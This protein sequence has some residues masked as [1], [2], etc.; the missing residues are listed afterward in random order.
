MIISI[1]IF[2]LRISLLSREQIY[3]H[4]VFIF[5]IALFNLFE[6]YFSE[7]CEPNFTY[8]PQIGNNLNIICLT[9]HLLFHWFVL[10]P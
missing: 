8:F 9:D 7:L 1:I 5:P 6:I 4:L 3:V 10:M 2:V